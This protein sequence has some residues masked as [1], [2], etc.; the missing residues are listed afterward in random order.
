MHRMLVM[1]IVGTVLDSNGRLIKSAKQAVKY[2]QNK[3]VKVTLATTRNIHF[4]KG[5]A[6]ALNLPSYII[7]HHGAYIADQIDH[8]LYARRLD[9]EVVYDA[10][11]FLDSLDCEITLFHESIAISNRKKVD[12]EFLGRVIIAPKN[13]SIYHYQY[14]NNLSEA[15]WREQIKP[16]HIK[17]EFSNTLE[18]KEGASL[19]KE[20]F[21]EIEIYQNKEQLTLLPKGVSKLSGILYLCDLWQIPLEETAVI[22]SS[23][24]DL[25]S[26]EAAGLGVA[27]GNAPAEVKRVADWVTRSSRED[28]VW[29]FAFEHFRKQQPLEFLE[30]MAELKNLNEP[31]D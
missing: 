9:E 3:G 4:A 22:G 13:Q 12:Q 10:V 19:L 16:T 14:V 8:P 29:Y 30:K 25:E 20:I 26:V 2:V 31:V 23:M 5:I 18:A 27:M 15:L 21:Y 1:N 24:Y 11:R 6:K 28:G 17:A 7:A